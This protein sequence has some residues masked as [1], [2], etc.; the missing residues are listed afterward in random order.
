MKF[1]LIL[2]LPF[3]AYSQETAEP[4]HK[5][6]NR[7][8]G[9]YNDTAGLFKKVLIKMVDRGYSIDNKDSE[10]GLINFRIPSIPGYSPEGVVRMI[11]RDSTLTMSGAALNQFRFDAMY[12]KSKGKTVVTIMWAEL[13]K[14]MAMLEPASITYT[15]VKE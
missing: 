12:I 8:I 15:Q 14:I 13:E 2:L 6:S 3:F 11:I 4:V 10:A 9:H 1:F 5:K 7:I